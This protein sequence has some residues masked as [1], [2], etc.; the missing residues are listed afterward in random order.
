LTYCF[1]TTV[2]TG[3]T[4][5]SHKYVGIGELAHDDGDYIY[6]DDFSI[7]EEAP[8]YDVVYVDDDA[9]AGWYDASHVHT[10][11]EGINNV[12][13]EGTVYVW[14]GTYSYAY[15]NKNISLIGNTSNSVIID[16]GQNSYGIRLGVSG[17]ELHD[18]EVSGIYITNFT[19]G[20]IIVVP[21]VHK[22][23]NIS[24]H[25]IIIEDSV[26][27]ADGGYGIWLFANNVSIDNAIIKDL[28]AGGTEQSLR[29][30]L[31]DGDNNTINNTEI[32]NFSVN[33]S[34]A[35]DYIEFY[36]IDFITG[37]NTVADNISISNFY[38]NIGRYTAFYIDA[39]SNRYGTTKNCNI[40]DLWF[41]G[42]Y[43]DWAQIDGL[44]SNTIKNCSLENLSIYVSNESSSGVYIYGAYD[45]TEINGS[46]FSNFS[47]SG[48]LN[49]EVVGIYATS[50]NAY[51]F[52][53]NINNIS[54][55]GMN[56]IS[57]GNKVYHNY[58]INNT[59]Q[60]IDNG[61]NNQWDDGYPSGGNYWDDYAGNDIYHG[62]NQNLTGGDGIGD[63]PYII[64]GTGGSSTTTSNY[65]IQSPVP[66]HNRVSN[67]V[68]LPH[69]GTGIGGNVYF[70]QT[71]KTPDAPSVV[72]TH[73]SSIY[74]VRLTA[75][76]TIEVSIWNT[77][78]CNGS[79]GFKNIYGEGMGIT[80][81]DEYDL[82]PDTRISDWFVP[83]KEDKYYPG[84]YWMGISPNITLS[85]NT[86]Y[87]VVTRLSDGWYTKM[88]GVMN[89]YSDAGAD[90]YPDGMVWGSRDAGA[91]WDSW[92]LKSGGYSS[93]DS[94][95]KATFA[96]LSS[97][98]ANTTSSP[99]DR[100]PFYNESHVGGNKPPYAN[101]TVYPVH[102]II[103]DTIMFNDTSFDYD[104]SISSWSWNFGDGNSSS[105]QSPTH[106]YTGAGIYP[107]TL[108]VTDNGSATDSKTTYVF[109]T[110]DPFDP[111]NMTDVP[112]ADFSYS[113]NGNTVTFTDTST[114]DGTIVNWTW[115]LGDGNVSYS[116]NP[117][118]NYSI[119][120]F[121][122]T[123]TVTDDDGFS[124]SVSKGIFLYG[125]ADFTFNPLSPY[126]DDDVHFTDT[127]SNQSLIIQRAW[128][129]GDGFSGD[130]ATVTHSY[131]SADTY[132]PSLTVTYRIGMTDT[133]TKSITVYD[134]S[135]PPPPPPSP[136]SDNNTYIIPPLQPPIYPEQ[137]YTIPE[138][139]ELIGL[140]NQTAKG[141]V[142]I[143]VID[144]GVTPRAYSNGRDMNID[145]G[146]IL[147][148]AISKY[149]GT[150]DNGHG[151]F[152]NAE[153]HWVVEHNCPNVIQYS[154]KAVNSDGSCTVQD[155]NEA[156]KIA[157]RMHV[158]VIS[159]SLGGN[160]YLGDYLD[161]KVRE[162]AR[163]GI[164]VV[165][166]AGNYGP[167]SGTITS[168]ALS[169]R[170]IA[171]ASEDPMHTI[172]SIADD[173]VSNFSSRGPVA[174]SSEIKPNVIA[175]GESIVGPSI[176]GEVI[177][178]GTSLA[179]PV[180][181]GGVA[182]M[183]SDNAKLLKVYDALYWWD[184]FFG[185]FGIKS[186][187]VKQSLEE[188]CRPLSSGGQYDYGHGLPNIPDAS[189]YLRQRLWQQIIMMILAYILLIA[190]IAVAIYLK[191]YH[192]HL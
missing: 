180:I 28:Y 72:L 51:V 177:W 78:L 29:G 96:G 104:G 80:G 71:F 153:V 170:A 92:F 116:Q 66:P 114:D 69:G 151:T 93:F 70:A 32:Y 75:G 31:L 94:S 131:G 182:Y 103:N 119:A 16:A 124:D 95:F 90:A 183:L 87:A 144:T 77:T 146:D 129:F 82:E 191:L 41:N 130:G 108:T 181:A 150:D 120:E 178:S 167:Y 123:L 22:M 155:L 156:F 149:G 102:P 105:A 74:C 73:Y 81:I 101:F 174:G 173:V 61:T 115:E 160:G 179:T 98:G 165:V 47:V 46:T 57:G 43:T 135:S 79:R 157:E 67:V 86:T 7:W 14:N 142:R 133:A 19:E 137:P 172:D 11:Q 63:T 56:M 65:V 158:D 163:K 3:V 138:M 121:T 188:S 5:E 8:S 42:T 136:P 134:R 30:I 164:I 85:G 59:I 64:E 186:K 76:G 161:S 50:D 169:P 36:G 148:Y 175:G 17:Y 33:S 111:D 37:H 159:L 62:V 27:T 143:A 185:A 89:C 176:D 55:V 152:V 154:I 118:H 38:C 141:K 83:E 34:W 168:P 24:I 106:H 122:V 84:Y 127:S 139:Y 10:I 190:I 53:S 140:G 20:G 12:S 26:I 54:G 40:H 110:T 189:Q 48:T 45:F 18:I 15:I 44:Y 52:D 99:K 112:T 113:I 6:Y 39:I 60:A 162:L 91:S 49:K 2:A 171:V 100:Y 23:N 88:K 128:L 13:E 35:A 126:V 147:V 125:N 97:P 68:G 117:V 1:N 132:S 166:A 21:P 192:T 4:T 9:P 107:V 25:D 109:V 145:M 58:F 187:I 184:N